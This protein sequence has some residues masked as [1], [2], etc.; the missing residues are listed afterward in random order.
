MESAQSST[1][2]FDTDRFIQRCREAVRTPDPDGALVAL[3]REAVSDPAAVAAAVPKVE[4]GRDE[5]VLFSDET[6]SVYLVKQFPEV[7][8]PPHDHGMTAVVGMYDGVEVHHL[9]DVAED[10]GLVSKP[11][12][13]VGPGDVI[14]LGP[15][16]VHAISN[17]SV[18]PTYGLHVYHGDLAGHRRSIWNLKTGERALF[19]ED[20]YNALSY[21]AGA[22]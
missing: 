20:L 6:V 19:T 21:R 10:G 18:A 1:A 7:G 13:N 16:D 8:G 4:E 14:H 12:R 5:L 11:T 17:P 2:T 22:A 3:M 9:W 15:E